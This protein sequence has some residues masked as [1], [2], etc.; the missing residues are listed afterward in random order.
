MVGFG[1]LCSQLP[2]LDLTL[3]LTH[4]RLSSCNLVQIR[5]I[6]CSQVVPHLGVHV[7]LTNKNQEEEESSQQVQ[8]VE[9]GKDCLNV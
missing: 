4:L 7:L 1:A 6:S 8:C 3:T 2:L 9:N 5:R